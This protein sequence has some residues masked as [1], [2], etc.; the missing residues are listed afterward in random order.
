M[1][2]YLYRVVKDEEEGY[3]MITVTANS[4]WLKNKCVSDEETRRDIVDFLEENGFDEVCD[5]T[6]VGNRLTIEQT[7]ELLKSSDLFELNDDFI[8]FLDHLFD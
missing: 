6:F 5:S 4:Y 7:N 1:E 3:A 2:K 8:S